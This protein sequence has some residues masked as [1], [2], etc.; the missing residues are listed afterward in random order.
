MADKDLLI[1]ILGDASSLSGELD[2]AGGQVD[3]FSK[4]I[5]KIGTAMLGVGTVITGAA[6]TI[7]AKTADIG[8]QFDKMSKRTGVAV[9]DLSALS[10]AA[11]ISGTNI[12]TVE[13]GLRML[14]TNIN[15]AAQGVGLAKD[16]FEELNIATADTEGNLRPTVD[17]LKEAATK[18]AELEDETKQVALA[19]EIF[20][21]RYGT[22]LLPLLK[23][24]GE[25]IDELMGR[26]QELGIVIST[27]AATN[28]AEY[29]DSMTDL[30]ESLAGTGRI[31]G[32]TLIPA[33]TPLIEKTTEI[34]AKVSDW[35]AANP[36]LVETIAKI[37]VILMA[38]GAVLKGLVL[39][40]GAIA[41]IGTMTTGPIGLLIL[42]ITG[43]I[44]VWK[45]WD[46]IIAFVL[47][48]KDKIIGYLTDL[49]D[50][51][52]QKIQEMIDWI[53]QKFEDLANLPQKMLDWGK[54][55]IGGFIDGILGRKGDMENAVEKGITEPLA[56]NLAFRSPPKRGL[57]HDSDKWM[58]N[59]MDMFADGIKGGAPGIENA[60]TAITSGIETN[61]EDMAENT[62]LT[63]TG[64]TD[65]LENSITIAS[66]NIESV[67]VTFADNFMNIFES[68]KTDF[69]SNFVTPV[70]GYLEDQLADA[71]Y[72]LL[73][74]ADDF[75]WSWKSFWEGLKQI[76]IRA[77]AEMIAKLIVLASFSWL[78]KLIG[79]PLSWLGISKGGGIDYEKGGEAEY[80]QEGG[81]RGTDII[82]A[83]LTPGEYVISKP[84]VDFIRR[85]KAI[86]SELAAAI[87][88][89]MPTPM[90]AFAGGG[91]VE[92]I[93][94]NFGGNSF[95]IDIH[96]NKISDDV[97]IRK[98]ADTVS[99]E[100]VKKMERNK[101]F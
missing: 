99:N 59:M 67:T 41:A 64:M 4:K 39:L 33:I 28:A 16:A 22:E 48:W 80:Y 37:G 19:G 14:A 10:Y 73:T 101:K 17:V 97:D 79:L 21:R 62:V 95:Y 20:G 11:E 75:E 87:A 15:D 32:D 18:I 98:L 50:I 35:V 65:D 2:K 46:E 91:M 51:A 61:F 86:P 45:N 83:W 71:I 58:P 36:E 9:E 5:D 44:V 40:K 31:I 96:D 38:G 30:T 7:V 100:I 63:F 82:P 52:T 69:K 76:L 1:K 49:K 57:L 6:A 89:G 90:P 54:N 55:A 81:A 25:G 34:I 93:P 26:A 88:M 70:I 72:G 42:A 94:G 29:T 23:E 74:N 77:V 56:G 8:D 13:N 66:E 43:I 85:V 27:E 92:N 78:F 68:L 24:G 3:N 12:G 60:V 53:I 84:M 47:D